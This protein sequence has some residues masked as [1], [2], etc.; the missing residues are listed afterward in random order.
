MK[1]FTVLVLLAV[2]A[3]CGASDRNICEAS[4]G[5]E[6][7]NPETAQFFDFEE[8]TQA[9]YVE[10]VATE[11][12]AAVGRDLTPSQR[13]ELEDGFRQLFAEQDL[14]LSRVRVRSEGREGNV[15]T[16]NIYCMSSNDGCSCL[17]P[18]AEVN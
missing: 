15:V 3:G 14:A 2:L 7:L 4:A 17:D 13:G 16:T 1:K 5:R 11:G 18:R 12:E 8:L 6:V 10:G 9:Q